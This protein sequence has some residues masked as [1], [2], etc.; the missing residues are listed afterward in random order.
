MAPHGPG[1]SRIDMAR[2]Q[3]TAGVQSMIASKM[4][5]SCVNGRPAP[6]SV[7]DEVVDDRTRSGRERL[8]APIGGARSVKPVKA[9][10][11]KYVHA[12]RP[13]SARPAETL[14]RSPKPRCFV[15]R[16]DPRSD[17]YDA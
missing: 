14:S 11:Q 12:S 17:P 8:P 13:G 9:S 5:A 1:R 3:A 7:T 10:P 16:I 15:S 4:A 2:S 6:L